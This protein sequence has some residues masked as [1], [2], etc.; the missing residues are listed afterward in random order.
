ML[1]WALKP[2]MATFLENTMSLDYCECPTWVSGRAYKLVKPNLK[3]LWWDPLL[4]W[5]H[6]ALCKINPCPAWTKEKKKNKK[7]T[8]RQ[9]LNR[10]EELERKRLITW[11]NI[12]TKV[13]TLYYKLSL[14][15]RQYQPLKISKPYREQR[16]SLHTTWLKA[17]RPA[18]QWGKL[19]QTGLGKLSNRNSLV[20]QSCQRGL[21][22]LSYLWSIY[23]RTG[24]SLLF[25][26]SRV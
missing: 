20:I 10:S 21:I 5:T 26:I 7:Q 22:T 1:R 17:D 15:C 25:S 18:N 4:G 14:H 11:D 8:T 13:V 6:L 16:T 3:S 23:I 19:I 24:T 9:F 2:W 12:K